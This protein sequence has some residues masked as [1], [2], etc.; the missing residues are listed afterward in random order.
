MLLTVDGC[1]REAAQQ[2][3]TAVGV[4]AAPIDHFLRKFIVG[5]GRAE[6]PLKCCQ[7]VLA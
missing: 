6:S 2:A 7:D 5:V 3:V 1:I 4:S